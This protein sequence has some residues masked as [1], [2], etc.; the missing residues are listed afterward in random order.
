MFVFK[1]NCSVVSGYREQLGLGAELGDD[2]WSWEEK[3]VVGG[4]DC[5]KRSRGIPVKTGVLPTV[6]PDLF[7]TPFFFFFFLQLTHTLFT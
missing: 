2:G 3:M 4:S 6:S 5:L 7:T 1:N